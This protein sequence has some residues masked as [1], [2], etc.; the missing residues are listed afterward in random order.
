VEDAMLPQAYDWGPTGPEEVFI[1]E[2]FIFCVTKHSSKN[3]KYSKCE[4]IKY[5]TSVGKIMKCKLTARKT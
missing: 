2:F 3:R 4:Y 1:K 5:S